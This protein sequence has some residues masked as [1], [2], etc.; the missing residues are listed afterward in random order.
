MIQKE[1]IPVGVIGATGMVGQRFVTLLANHPWFEIKLLAASTRSAGQKYEE[2]I[3]GRWK[4][5][6]SLPDAVKGFIVQDASDIAQV[7][8][9]VGLAFCAVDMDLAATKKLENDYASAGVAV[10]SN[11]SAHRTS[12]DV[13]MIMPEVNPEHVALIE[14]QRKAHGWSTGLIV[15]K[16]NCSIQ[17]YVPALTA[18]RAFGPKRVVVT[19]FQAIS[20]AGRTLDAAPELVDNVV[21][22]IDGEE[23]KSETEPLKIWGHV[24]DGKIVNANIPTISATCTRVPVSDGHMASVSV[25]F[26]KDPTYEELI[27]ALSDYQSPIADLNLPSAPDKFIQYF[28][29]PDRPQTRLDRE[30]GGGMSVS[31]GRLRRD[32]ALGWKFICLSHNTILGAAGGAV[33]MAELLAAKG[34]I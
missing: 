16:C 1:K 7:A 28:D 9:K 20:G 14:A 23:E 19:T 12:D 33:L 25:E 31:V 11:N 22:F 34:Y 6:D 26:E 8:K 17:S 2:A 15:V 4:I 30:L 13:P 5:S 3:S 29:E 32:P 18:W 10:V 27:A 24:E 21:P